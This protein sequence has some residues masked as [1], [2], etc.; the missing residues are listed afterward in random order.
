MWKY[1]LFLSGVFIALT[2]AGCGPIYGIFI[3][4]IRPKPKIPAE[5]NLRDKKVL[6]WVERGDEHAFGG[7]GAVLRYELTM[8]LHDELKKHKAADALVA[9]D[10]IARY[11][12]HNP[13]WAAENLRDIGSY[14][15]ADEVLY[16]LIEHFQLRHAAGH[17]Y[18]DAGVSGQCKV[19]D[20]ESGKRLWPRNETHRRFAA[21]GQITSGSG[22][23]FEASEVRK[24]CQDAAARIAIHFY[25]HKK[26]SND[27][28]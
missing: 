22:Q 25:T 21:T 2:A 1:I 12:H 24:L 5:H 28:E 6:V 11:R 8:K 14:F 27:I 19:I 7:E 17:D 10:E 9:Y 23:I 20:V 13:D 15:K 26:K 16:V 18:Y 3:E 4:P